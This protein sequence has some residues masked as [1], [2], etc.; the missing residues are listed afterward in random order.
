MREHPILNSEAGATA[1][2][3]IIAQILADVPKDA[4]VTA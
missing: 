3:W 1:G 4:A 2:G